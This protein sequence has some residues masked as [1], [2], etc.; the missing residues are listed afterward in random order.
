VSKS[1]YCPNCD[2]WMGLAD[3]IPEWCAGCGGR[4]R[5]SE[6]PETLRDVVKGDTLKGKD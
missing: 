2:C 6:E 4:V 5:G 3:N 1:R